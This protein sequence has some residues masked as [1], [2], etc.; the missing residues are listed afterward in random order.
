MRPESLAKHDYNVTLDGTYTSHGVKRRP[1]GVFMMEKLSRK[2]Q[3][4]LDK[5]GYYWDLP[6]MRMNKTISNTGQIIYTRQYGASIIRNSKN[7]RP[8]ES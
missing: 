3:Q 5:R 2:K 1:S 6:E 7:V 8:K 4:S